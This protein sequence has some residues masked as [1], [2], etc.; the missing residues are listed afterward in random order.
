MGRERSLRNLKR[1]G[2]PGRKPGVPNNATLEVKAWAQ[3]ILEDPQVREQTLALARQ[4]RL[5]PGIMVEL[6]HYAYGKP[7]D[8]TDV[9]VRVSRMI[10]ISPPTEAPCLTST[11]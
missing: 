4:G 2:Q 6:L 5:P 1:G 7:K 3:S 8:T 11:T 9:N 10:R